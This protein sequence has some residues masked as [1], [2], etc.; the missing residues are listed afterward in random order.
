MTHLPVSEY[1]PGFI[2]CVIHSLSGAQVLYHLFHRWESDPNRPIIIW[3]EKGETSA[4]A[5]AIRVALSKERK[6]RGLPRT[7][8]LKFSEQWPYTHDGIKGEALKITR[9][10]GTMLTRMRAAMLSI[11]KGEGT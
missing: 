6:A 10:G 9:H 2:N 3:C 7:F 11:N 8:E 1:D 5:N 4:K